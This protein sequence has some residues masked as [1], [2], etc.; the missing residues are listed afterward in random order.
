LPFGQ[1][2]QS[3][4][5]LEG[6]KVPAWQGKQTVDAGKIDMKPALQFVQKLE[7]AIEEKVPGTQSWQL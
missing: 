4:L 7:P 2:R 5:P 3:L 1:G 6:W